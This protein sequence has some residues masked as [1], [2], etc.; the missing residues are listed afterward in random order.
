MTIKRIARAL[1]VIRFVVFLHLGLAT[2]TTHNISTLSPRT[3]PFLPLLENVAL[4]YKYTATYLSETRLYAKNTIVNLKNIS[5]CTSSSPFVS[6]VIHS[7]DK[8]GQREPV[9]LLMK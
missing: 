2:A 6:S 8:N 9:R 4:A 3:V 1:R 5:R 7:I